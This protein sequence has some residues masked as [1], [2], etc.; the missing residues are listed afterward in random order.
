MVDYIDKEREGA[1]TVLHVAPTPFFSDRGCHVRIKGIVSAL[2]RRS[3]HNIVCTYHHGRDVPEVETRRISKIPG[4]TK[5]EAGPS[6]YKYLADV[7][8]FIKVLIVAWKKQ[9]DIIHGHLHEG[10]LIGWAVN[11]VLFWRKMPLVSDIQGSLVGELETYG[12]FENSSGL[13]RVFLGI[14]HY[15]SRLP[16][17][18]IC[19][20]GASANILRSEFEI[21]SSRIEVIN[22]GVDVTVTDST[23]VDDLR[24]Q[25]GLPRNRPVI[26]YTGA[27]LPAKGVEVLK[28]VIREAVRQ[29]LAGHFLIVGYPKEE[30]EGLVRQRDI[31]EYCTV[32][33]RVP[34]ED[35]SDYLE[36]AT[37]AIEPKDA[38]SGEASGKLLNY[39]GAGL[40][41]VCFDTENNK[42]F[43]GESGTFVRQKSVGVFVERIEA[44]LE[45]PDV[46]AN[47]GEMARQRA[48]NKFS[49]DDSA[50]RI[51]SIYRDQLA[52]QV[53]ARA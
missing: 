36:L 47:K 33:G 15:I 3:V 4:Y 37:V 23:R 43:L 31:D 40:P 30:M 21:S 24:G 10:T 38:D 16:D 11:A 42:K 19:S 41:V 35:L 27:L 18:I 45:N 17:F 52:E 2:N 28:G 50:E 13:R 46:R 9:P 32:T 34:F 5:Q 29:S 14:E 44:L 1:L 12:Y 49:W 51:Y 6:P 22:D 26:I 25:L 39:M 48:Q 20:S 53:N 7:L 8:L